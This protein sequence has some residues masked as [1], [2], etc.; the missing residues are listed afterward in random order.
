MSEHPGSGDPVEKVSL[1]GDPKRR[2]L[3]ELVVSRGQPIGRDEAAAAIGISRELA[4]FHLDRLVAGGL[5]DAEYRRLSGR[6]GPGAGRPAKLY[7]RSAQEVGVSLPARRY[8]R[9]A[10]LFAEALSGLS[11]AG[12]T[13][14]VQG[15]ARS[16][17]AELGSR[18]RSKAVRGADE[19]GVRTALIGLLGDAGFEPETDR[20]DGDIRLRNCPYRTLS[21]QHR[22]LTC[23]MNL[24]WASG[25]VAGLADEALDVELRP[26]PGSCCVIF[27]DMR[28]PSEPA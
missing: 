3:Y 13:E 17:G 5:L 25:V 7:R 11:D 16:Q 14:A 21:E 26:E 18:A 9:A 10:G 12:G 6:T 23:G 8:D 15:A 19:H 22:D 27:R 24:A 20:P 28:E 2:R 4:A 1:L